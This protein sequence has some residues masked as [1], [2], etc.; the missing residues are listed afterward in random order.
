M[1]GAK[2][3][4]L[5]GWE[6]KHEIME[7]MGAEEWEWVTDLYEGLSV[8]E[9]ENKMWLQFRFDNCHQLAVAIHEEIE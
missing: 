2:L 1:I 5:T 7:R 4:E 9:I 6:C 3:T 8:E